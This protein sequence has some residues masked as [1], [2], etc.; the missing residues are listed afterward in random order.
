MPARREQ[1]SPLTSDGVGSSPAP[2]GGCC[3]DGHARHDGDLLVLGPAVDTL[4]GAAGEGKARADDV[5]GFG[6][7]R[8]QRG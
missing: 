6:V 2:V 3:S 7:P 4:G 5:Y 8:P 1:F